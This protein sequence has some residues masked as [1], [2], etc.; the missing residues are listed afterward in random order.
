[1]IHIIKNENIINFAKRI[2]PEIQG[3]TIIVNPVNCVGVCGAGLALAMKGAYPENYEAYR[4]YCNEGKLLPGDIFFFE[5]DMVVN[6]A[7]KNHWKNK[8][9]LD[10]VTKCIQKTLE[11]CSNLKIT[12]LLMP[13]LGCGLGGLK[14]SDVLKILEESY[15]EYRIE[16]YFLDFLFGLNIFFFSRS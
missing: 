3:R 14:E 9:D 8:S 1:M 12:N 10:S 2:S 7:T 11:L 4:Q 15:N 13:A 5:R 16:E 6:A